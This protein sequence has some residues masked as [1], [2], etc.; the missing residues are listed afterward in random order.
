MNQPHESQGEIT[1]LLAECSSGNAEA[2]DR[3][4]PL[5]Y[6]DLRRIAHRR[7][8]MERGDHTLNTTAVVHE[9]YLRLV[10]QATAT[11]RDRTHFFAVAA[12]VIRRLLIDYARRHRAQKRGGGQ[13]RIPLREDLEGE[14]PRMV[15]VL[16]IDEAL[17][18]LAEYDARLERIVECRFF[19]GMTMPDTAEALGL[20]LRT[21]ERDWTRAKAY[22]FKALGGDEAAI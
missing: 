17:T 11:W 21:A 3:L 22:L 20:S 6:D 14:D 19:G 7:L 1:Q 16:A 5:V 9:A 4:V 13:I 12:K 10:N 2:L 15:D 8:Q 18:R